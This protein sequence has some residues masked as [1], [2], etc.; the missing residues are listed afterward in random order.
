MTSKIKPQN[1]VKIDADYTIR[2]RMY[3]IEA[4]AVLIWP[5]TDQN[6]HFLNKVDKTRKKKHVRGVKKSKF[7]KNRRRLDRSM[8]NYIT[9]GVP[10]LICPETCQNKY[11]LNI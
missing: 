2:C 5:E 6:T 4:V 7:R 1:C 8:Q 9:K 11:F 3:M 10:V